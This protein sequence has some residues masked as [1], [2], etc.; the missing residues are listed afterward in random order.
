MQL[1]LVVIVVLILFCALIYFLFFKKDEEP[2][3]PVERP[4]VTPVTEREETPI[5]PTPTP[6]VT[7]VSEIVVP[8]QAEIQGTIVIPERLIEEGTTETYP[9]YTGVEYEYVPPTAY[10]PPPITIPSSVNFPSSLSS[11]TIPSTSINTQFLPPIPITPGTP[12]LSGLPFVPSIPVSPPNMSGEEFGLTAG[13][14]FSYKELK[15]L[16]TELIAFC[17]EAKGSNMSTMEKQLGIIGIL[18]KTLGLSIDISKIKTFSP[19]NNPQLMQVVQ[20]VDPVT[21][22]DKNPGIPARS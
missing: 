20:S 3:T 12:P 7:P 13:R 10:E 8:P 9:A 14:T 5:N 2:V 1:M 11:T 21:C 22:V 6:D 4:T 16:K 19:P 17:E 18:N 15:M